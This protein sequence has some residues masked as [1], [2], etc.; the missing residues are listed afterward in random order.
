MEGRAKD[1]C[2]SL[3]TVFIQVRVMRDDL[4]TRN[5]MLCVVRRKIGWLITSCGER[6]ASV[7]ARRGLVSC[8][9]LEGSRWNVR[10]IFAAISLT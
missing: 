9:L 2:W 1:V 3:L 10:G 5:P 4:A 6:V 7:V 8:S